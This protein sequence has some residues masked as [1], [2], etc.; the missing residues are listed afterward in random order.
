MKAATTML[1]HEGWK[2]AKNAVISVFVVVAEHIG[3]HVSRTYLLLESLSCIQTLT[4]DFT[5][6]LSRALTASGT[7]VMIFRNIFS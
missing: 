5:Y 2:N 7:D 6:A 4:C 3:I 1:S